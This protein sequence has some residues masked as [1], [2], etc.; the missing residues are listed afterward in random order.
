M[1]C[2]SLL[3]SLH[4]EG[5]LKRSAQF[6]KWWRSD[7]GPGYT[8]HVYCLHQIA[9][10]QLQT[11]KVKCA[12]PYQIPHLKAT[13][14]HSESGLYQHKN[15]F[16]PRSRMVRR[17][18][19]WCGLC[20]HLAAV[21]DHDPAAAHHRV[22]PMGDDEGGAAAERTANG[23][24]DETICLCVDGCCRLIQYKNLKK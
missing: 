20:T 8:L 1:T 16:L 19:Q 21:Q 9:S 5:S 15:E 23:L 3:Y 13:H 10:A 17:R 12:L 22:Q 18:T 6:I 2:H 11:A 14:S 4:T 24:L 7:T